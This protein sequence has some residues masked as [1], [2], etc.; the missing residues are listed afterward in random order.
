M[1][2][3]HYF[4]GFLNSHRYRQDMRKIPF[5]VVIL[6]SLA[7]V[8]YAISLMITALRVKSTVGSPIIETIIY[9]IFASLIFIVAIGIYKKRPSA[10]TPFFVIQFFA[11]VISYTLIAGTKTSYQ[12]SGVVI[13]L[14]AVIGLV[15]FLKNAGSR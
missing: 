13:G 2:N 8:G 10:N 12:I 15:S 11:L 1:S 14:F 9:L 4:Q 3:F 6:E 5:T 7:V